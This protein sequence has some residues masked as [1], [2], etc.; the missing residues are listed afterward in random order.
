MEKLPLFR[1]YKDKCVQCMKNSQFRI[2]F[3]KKLFKVSPP[4][5]CAN[6]IN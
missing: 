4:K 6:K 1:G 5:N 2:I 3:K